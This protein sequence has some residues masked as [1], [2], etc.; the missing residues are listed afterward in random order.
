MNTPDNHNI[1]KE[2]RE[3]LVK[4]SEMLQAVITRMT[5]NSLAVKQ[6]A[7]S[8]W[9]A[10]VGFGFTNKTPSLFVLAIIS[11]ILLA[12]LDMYYLFLERRFRNNFN[13]LTEILCGFDEQEL[14]N[15]RK[16]RGNFLKIEAIS[17]GQE[18]QMYM[19]TIKSWANLPYLVVIVV[20]LLI[21]IS[22]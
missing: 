1:V 16:L 15:I 12:F 21:V 20:T 10:L 7:F 5:A 11:V 14:E 3:Y 18:F 2:N 13:R 22:Q 6:L 8:I 9:A 17:A 19:S 4:Q